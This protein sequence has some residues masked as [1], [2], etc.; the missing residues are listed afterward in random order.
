[1]HRMGISCFLAALVALTACTATTENGQKTTPEAPQGTQVVSVDPWAHEFLDSKPPTVAVAPSEDN[2]CDPSRVTE[3]S[4]A[5]M[6]V[7]SVPGVVHYPEALCFRNPAASEE[8]ACLEQDLGWKILDGLKVRGIGPT[9]SPGVQ[10][11]PVYLK[12][13]D[14]TVCVASSKS[15]MPPAGDY[16]F[17][18]FCNDNTFYYAHV[19]SPPPQ[20]DS[21]PFADET[22]D[23]GHWLIRTSEGTSDQLP[24]R[25]VETAYK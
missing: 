24:T 23:E 3:R 20:D 18:G 15:A 7:F 10:G 1:M 19:V 21:N 22:D 16:P 11:R 8:Y 2:W 5:Y 4:D 9:K 6:C 13:T 17:L 14:G 25:A 12:L